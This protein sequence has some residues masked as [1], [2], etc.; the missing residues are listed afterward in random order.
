MFETISSAKINEACSFTKNAV[1]L[2][3]VIYIANTDHR[4]QK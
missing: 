3:I 2:Y 4:F 1:L